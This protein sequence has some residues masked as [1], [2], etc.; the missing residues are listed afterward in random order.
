[1]KTKEKIGDKV[2][3]LKENRGIFTRMLIVVTSRQDVT[4]EEVV[5]TYELSVVPRSMFSAGGQMN[6]CSDK[7]A[8]M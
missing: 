6:H 5:S 4:I 7:S 3:E 8:V 1:M 2:V